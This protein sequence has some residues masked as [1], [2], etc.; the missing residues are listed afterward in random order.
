MA[1]SGKLPDILRTYALRFNSP[2]VGI[3]ELAEY[4]HRYAQRN[5]VEKPDCAQYLDISESRL[6]TELEA[7]ESEGK[8][9]LIDDKRKG[10]MLFIP[11]FFLDKI[12]RQ[13][14]SI[15]EKPELPFP[16]ASE[17]PQ[18]FSKRFLRYIR[19]N[20]DFTDLE[21]ETGNSTFLYQ[22]GFPDDTPALIFPA[23]SFRRMNCGILFKKN[24]L[25]RIRAKS[26]LL[27]NLCLPFKLILPKQCI[28]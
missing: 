9:E 20:T 26:T 23:F 17:I 22:L 28:R 11:F 3:S 2:F 21:P 18:N 6:I 12:A 16:L 19:I 15:K 5:M 8:V 25:L 24:S 14:D 13:Y 4:L 27:E 10:K 7:L 1:I